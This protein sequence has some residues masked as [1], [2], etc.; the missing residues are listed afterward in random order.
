[1]VPFFFIL[2]YAQHPISRFELFLTVSDNVANEPG[3]ASDFEQAM[4][5]NALLACVLSLLQEKNKAVNNSRIE[6]FIKENNQNQCRSIFQL[7]H[8][9]IINNEVIV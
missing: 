8:P 1:M 3:R 4:I 2:M 6:V 5:E 9:H 7:I